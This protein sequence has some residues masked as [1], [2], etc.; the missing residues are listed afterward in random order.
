MVTLLILVAWKGIQTEF[1]A[2]IISKRITEIATKQLDAEV[3]FKRI[4]FSLFP[5]GTKIIEANVRNK[6]TDASIT[7]NSLGIYFSILDFITNR[8]SISKVFI[9]DGV[10]EFKKNGK[11]SEKLNMTMLSELYGSI[12]TTDF[13]Y[14][15]REV[16]LRRTIIKQ[17]GIVLINIPH[18]R[19]G[20]FKDNIIVNGIVNRLNNIHKTLEELKLDEIEFDIQCEKDKIRL[21][22]FHAKLK[23]DALFGSGEAKL[24]GD[25]WDF[26]GEVNY[27]GE[28]TPILDFMVKKGQYAHAGFIKADLRIKSLRNFELSES[29]IELTEFNVG[30]LAGDKLELKIKHNHNYLELVTADYFNNNGSAR[31]ATGFRFFNTEK[32]KLLPFKT[33]LIAD[34]LHSNDFLYAIKDNLG[35]FKTRVS[36]AIGVEYG[37]NGSYWFRPQEG[38]LLGGIV[39]DFN[40]ENYLLNTKEFTIGKGTSFQLD[41]KLNFHLDAK[42]S[43][44]WTNL[45]AEGIISDKNTEIK[46]QD[47]QLDIQD[48]GQIAGIDIRGKG[49]LDLDISGPHDKV[50]FKFNTEIENF[51][52]VGY[53][54]GKAQCNFAIDLDRKKIYSETFTSSFE[55]VEYKGNFTFNY[56]DNNKFKINSHISEGNFK[57]TLKMVTPL[58]AKFKDQLSLMNF[59]FSADYTFEGDFSKEQY[60][61]NGKVTGKNYV[62]LTED[63]P[64]INFDISFK[65]NIFSITNL[66][67]K[68]NSGKVVGQFFTNVKTGFMEYKSSVISIPVDQLSTLRSFSPGM[69]AELQGNFEGAGTEQS[70]STKSNLQLIKASVGGRK[71]RDSFVS[72]YN[73]GPDVFID[74]EFLD[75][76]A[77]VES[78]INLNPSESVRNKKSYIKANLNEKDFQRLA[79]LISEHNL[80][81]NDLEGEVGVSLYSTFDINRI[82]NLDFDL[83]INN[84]KIKKQNEYIESNPN[85]NRIIVENGKIQKWNVL[86]KTSKGVVKSIGNGGLNKNFK[87]VQ[88]FQLPFNMTR[89]IHPIIENPKGIVWGRNI[90]SG[91]RGKWNNFVELGG[92][93]IG[94][95]LKPLNSLFD[96]I[97]VSSVFENNTLIVEY[98]EGQFG[99]GKLKLDS[100]IEFRFP[101]P[102][103]DIYIGLEESRLP[104]FEQSYLV[105]NADINIRGS[106]FPY[107]A[108]GKVD[109]YSGELRDDLRKLSKGSWKDE[110]YVKY[111]PRAENLFSKLLD[112]RLQI[113]SINPLRIKNNLTDL[114]LDI[115]T[116]L[117]GKI[118]KPIV[119]GE[120]S[121]SEKNISRF[122]FKGHDFVLS[123]G[124]IIFDGKDEDITPEINFTGTSKIGEFDIHLN[125]SGPIDKIVI[126]LDSDPPL[127]QEDIFSLLTLG[128]TNT[129]TSS[130]QE[131]ERQSITT[132]SLGSLL[133][134]QLNINEGLGRTMGLRLSLEPEFEQD[135]DSLLYG[136]KDGD[137]SGRY[138]TSTKI[139]IKKKLSKKVDMAVSSTFGGTLEEK[140]EMNINYNLNEIMSL[141]GVYEIKSTQE[142]EID[143]NSLGADLK[144]RWNF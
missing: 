25:G 91:V 105:G 43:S 44:G 84:F 82:E 45:H 21:R 112:S 104:F 77:K 36:G 109:L 52:T 17:N 81:E 61:F 123:H 142:D 95:K 39:L 120:M 90:F 18:T 131:R 12:F 4:E 113:R 143:E 114:Y 92:K 24:K 124:R 68:K 23:E 107:S 74:A 135:E 59:D 136:L 50:L 119:T 101:Y 132:L 15:L 98:V 100:K 133:F 1:V 10:V 108:E 42:L 19:L 139:K 27:N 67:A 58:S 127:G 69:R 49:S 38:T 62:V 55:G 41:K 13:T 144:I 20:Y 22:K 116:N 5:L 57:S 79:G 6:K 37:V 87:I 65:D 71:L 51:E 11:K 26:K 70:F 60:I 141:E 35:A 28:L 103:V 64:R 75:K 83:T 102:I 9:D 115:D 46:V 33:K 53:K 111:V 122:M 94:F 128:F 86:L 88:N 30:Y 137:S 34:K 8:L 54:L 117:K 97:A 106:R 16:Y 125:V 110:S 3:S 121:L 93:D 138:K 85:F 48:L 14:H 140:Q 80:F 130:L 63:F 99:Q 2:S 134:D 129:H 89:L 96:G 76:V 72:V 66:V 126:G 40:S 118:Q 73:N 56:G 31:I 7:A 32:N 78:Y 29:S 47:G